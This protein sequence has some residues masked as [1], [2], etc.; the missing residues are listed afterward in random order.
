M[1]AN[2]TFFCGLSVSPANSTPWRK[3]RYANATPPAG[4][5]AKTADH[6]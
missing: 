2:G 4:I 3:P 6:P 1:I 5:A